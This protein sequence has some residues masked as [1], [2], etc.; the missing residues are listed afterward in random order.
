MEVVN[1]MPPNMLAGKCYNRLP[2]SFAFRGSVLGGYLDTK[3]LVLETVADIVPCET[4]RRLYIAVGPSGAQRI[5]QLTGKVEL[6]PADSYG[7]TQ[8]PILD[9]SGLPELRLRPY[10]F[11]NKAVTNM[12][13]I[14]SPDRADEEAGF[15]SVE[16]YI[17]I[18][19]NPPGTRAGVEESHGPDTN[20]ASGVTYY[21]YER[22]GTALLIWFIA[23]SG[24]TTLKILIRLCLPKWI[25][26]LLGALDMWDFVLKTR[27]RRR[28]RRSP[29]LE[30]DPV[31]READ[32]RIE[33]VETGVEASTGTMVR[34]GRRPALTGLRPPQLTLNQPVDNAIGEAL[35]I[36]PSGQ[37]TLVCHGETPGRRPTPIPQMAPPRPPRQYE[38]L[39]TSNE[40]PSRV[41]VGNGSTVEMRNARVYGE[42]NGQK[43]SILVDTGSIVSL[44]DQAAARHFGINCFP[45]TASDPIAITGVN[46]GVM[47]AVG[48]GWAEVCIG[49]VSIQA[50][51]HVFGGAVGHHTARYDLI[52]GCDAIQKFGPI[53]L[54]FRGGVLSL[55]GQSPTGTRMLVGMVE[56]VP[57][58]LIDLSRCELRDPFHVATLKR[59]LEDFSQVFARH[60]F[61]IGACTLT[62]PTIETTG[63]IPTITRA[64]PVPVK[65]KVELDKQLE[66]ML[67]AEI[68]IRS[69]TPWTSPLV[70]V[71]KANGELRCCTDLRALNMVTI[72]DPFPMPRTKSLLE[73][74]A[75]HQFYSSLDLAQGFWQIRLDPTSSWKC[76]FITEA[77]VFAF[78]RLPFGLKNAPSVFCRL[79]S[80]ILEG[81]EGV[82][83]YVDDLLV[84]ADSVEEH[85]RRLAA[86]LS[87]LAE[88][89]FKVKPEKCHLL[90]TSI[91]YLGHTIDQHGY[92]PSHSHSAVIENYPQ[93][94]STAELH[95]FVGLTG[96]FRS[97]VPNYAELVAPLNGLLRKEAKFEWGEAQAAAFDQLKLQLVSR[98]ILRPPDYEAPFHLF[99]DASSLAMG[100]ALMQHRQ[101]ESHLH[102]VSYCSRGLTPTEK[103]QS[104]TQAELGA[105]I[106][107]IQQFRHLLY[108]GRLVVHTDH[109]P[110]TFLFNHASSNAKIS[111]WLLVFQEL[112]P[113]V[114]YIQGRENRVADALSRVA[115]PWSDANQVIS[116]DFRGEAPYVLVMETR[117][118]KRRRELD[119]Q[120][121]QVERPPQPPPRH[122]EQQRD[123]SYDDE[124]E[125]EP[126]GDWDEVERPLTGDDI[127]E[128]M[129]R[130]RELQKVLQAVRSGWDTTPAQDP[131][132]A[133][134]RV[135]K[136]DLTTKE[137]VLFKGT[138]IVVPANVRDQL[139][140][141]LHATHLGIVKMK[142]IARRFF[143]W[144]GVGQSIETVA[145]LCEA[146]NELRAAEPRVAL[147]QWPLETAPMMRLH[148]DFCGPLQG[149]TFLLAVDAY[150]GYPFAR[151]VRRTTTVV[152]TRFLRD[153]FTTFGLAKTLVSDNGPQFTAEEFRRFVVSNG[154]T[155]VLAP[156]YH[157]RSNGLC[158]RFV[159]TLKRGVLKL[160]AEGIGPEEAMRMVLIAYRSTEH[161]STQQTPAALFLGREMITQWDALLTVTP[162]IR[163]ARERQKRGYDASTR[164]R[165]FEAGDPVWMVDNTGR[166]PKWVPAT[167]IESRGEAIY[168]VEMENG[169]TRTAH[170]DQLRRRVTSNPPSEALSDSGD[171]G[172]GDQAT[173]SPTVSQRDRDGSINQEFY[174]GGATDGAGTEDVGA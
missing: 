27:G 170:L 137:G 168:L 51:I 13:E 98:P 99:C 129:Q 53:V 82:V 161:C 60:K 111:R 46:G 30:L 153:I 4:N 5:D 90:R 49:G 38:E 7:K 107:A 158:E 162:R 63:P 145:A 131:E 165:E 118:M 47:R 155:H 163:E 33:V 74:A 50:E 32:P 84:Y 149:T 94:R 77:G 172:N 144:P 135:V 166:K 3:T 34:Q 73:K 120:E 95:R 122:Q 68:I 140:Q 132:L 83:V 117:G 86:V 119:A 1:F 147:R 21:L 81:L 45:E 31:L 88:H 115:I 71:Q 92:R 97:F 65:F 167:V 28:K 17:N 113:E 43:A 101:G 54:D 19:R 15:A 6:I 103:K 39:A 62:A 25:R 157:P 76:G 44:C 134:Y 106:Y 96:Y 56:E 35:P 124:T 160:R 156:P 152:V 52:L 85:H 109:R 104:A 126:F 93:P 69:T 18:L 154:V 12:T 55:P 23:T 64:R 70:L 58:L 141:R 66:G 57:E 171:G 138:R 174:S 61:D 164:E 150:S 10:V 14:Y 72:R 22:F 87:R 125:T 2:V 16:D 121:H 123:K 40:E 148:L 91:E 133:A 67:R 146:C 127:R 29:A 151:V 11:L 108:G 59:M 24:Y 48:Q 159:Q 114:A 110:L 75:G 173:P 37:R 139:L 143:W 78:L 100:A 128:A 116:E 112:M 105:I 8:F 79:I 20:L 89:G 136:S 142:S 9:D 169:R 26:R 130:D 80:G 102:V 41:Y 36:V 42:L